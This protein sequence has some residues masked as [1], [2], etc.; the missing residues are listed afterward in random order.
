MK[1]SSMP[2]MILIFFRS[3]GSICHFTSSSTTLFLQCWHFQ[4]H[5]LP[6]G[7]PFYFFY[8]PPI[9]P[10]SHIHISL[11]TFF[12]LIF[13]SSLTLSLPPGL[14]PPVSSIFFYHN[15]HSSSSRASIIEFGFSQWGSWF[16]NFFLFILVIIILAILYLP[17]LF[18]QVRAGK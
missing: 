16:N 17:L 2:F 3:D 14:F 10:Y 13:W 11:R 12:F 4:R 5:F 6:C 1:V 9:L 7:N 15:P 18:H 8:I